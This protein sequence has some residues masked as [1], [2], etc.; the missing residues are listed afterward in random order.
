MRLP[1]GILIILV[2]LSACGGSGFGAKGSIAWNATASE[3]DKREYYQGICLDKGYSLDTRE[4]DACI[5]SEPRDP[6]ARSS[7][8]YRS[9]D[10]N[11]LDSIERDLK[12][13][14]SSQRFDCIMSGGMWSGYSCT[15]R[16][17][18]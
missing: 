11:R 8:T 10:S 5:S 16:I 13:Q 3:S 17:G 12:R 7:Y 6:N 1:A 18:L 14:K 9:E 15:K 2:V 4:M